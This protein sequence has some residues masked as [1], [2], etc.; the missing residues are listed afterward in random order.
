MKKLILLMLPVIFTMQAKAQKCKT[1]DVPVAVMDAFKNAYPDSKKTCWGKDSSNFQVAFHN[2]KAPVSVTYNATGKRII[3]EMQMPVED[4]PQSIA[5]H[6]KKNYPGEIIIEAAQITDAE[7]IVT[8]EV[9]VKDLA[10]VFDAK[11]NYLQTLKC[12]E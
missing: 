6:I 8:Y 9:Q 10:L 11:G 2:G 1:K 4:M 12:Y 5:E 7:E 3:T